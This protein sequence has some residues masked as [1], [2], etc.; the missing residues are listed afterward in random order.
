MTGRSLIAA[1]LTLSAFLVGGA[2]AQQGSVGVP[3]YEITDTPE[4]LP[5]GRGREETF[6]ACVPCHSVQIVRR[7]GMTR[8][9]WDATMTEMA[10]RHNMAEVAGE[11]RALILEYLAT[12]FPPRARRG[13]PNPFLQR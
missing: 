12:S 5:E 11:D 3:T 6:Y 10:T 9:R 4:D 2:L 8:E 13:Q 1:G 7:Q